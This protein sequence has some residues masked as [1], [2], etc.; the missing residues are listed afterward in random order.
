[1]TAV[2][3][4]SPTSASAEPLFFC[5]RRVTFVSSDKS[6]QK[7]RLK[8]RFKTSSRA[9]AMI[10]RLP[11][12]RAT[13]FP[14][15]SGSK[16]RASTAFRDALSRDAAPCRGGCLGALPR[17]YR[18]IFHHNGRL[19]PP[20]RRRR[21]T[22]C[23]SRRVDADRAEKIPP[24]RRDFSSC[25]WQ[26]ADGVSGIR[27]GGLTQAGR[28]R[29]RRSLRSGSSPR[30]VPSSVSPPAPCRLTPWDPTG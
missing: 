17:G 14:V 9:S 24:R 13:G 27:Q 23:T 29:S 28:K 26:A 30:L 10:S 20:S 18:Q 25:R 7:R 22:V 15:F 2:S 11:V 3:L 21:R 16:D 19:C 12:P 4:T 1:M 6:H 5:L 8:L